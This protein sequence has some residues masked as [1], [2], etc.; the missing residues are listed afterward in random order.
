[1]RKCR[2]IAVFLM[3]MLMISGCGEKEA[4]NPMDNQGGNPVESPI[5]R[6][7]DKPAG[8]PAE[9]AAPDISSDFGDAEETYGD[10]IQEELYK[11]Y[12]E[13]A[14]SDLSGVTI[15]CLSGSDGC[16]IKEGS[17]ITFT[18]VSTDS[19]YTIAGEF[20][21][22]IVIDVGDEYKFEL[23]LL[24]LSVSSDATNPI[25]IKSGDKVT[26]T[27]KKDYS[28]Y[29]YDLRAAVDENSET[30]KAGAIYSE[31]DL[32]IGGKGELT[33]VSENN[34]GIHSKK[35]LEVKNVNLTVHCSDN[36]LKGNDSVTLEGASTTLISTM[37][38][39]IKTSNSDISQ[40]GN[41]RGTILVSGGTYNVYAACDGLD[42]AYDVVVEDTAD[43]ATVVN[44]FTDKYSNYS[45][46]VTVVAED[47][48]YI[49]SFT[50]EWKYSVKYYN[51]D[52][53]YVW[54]T[55]EKHSDVSGGRTSY[56]YYS[57]PKMQEYSKVQFFIYSGDMEQGQ[58]TEYLAMTD[59]LTVNTEYDTFALAS[60]GNSLSYSWTNYTTQIVES[61]GGGRGDH[62]G[63]GG[64]PGGF[65]GGPGGFGGMGG[66]GEGNTD[67][68]EYSTKGIK[69]ANEIVINSGTVNIKAYDDA[70]HANNDSTL[71]NGETPKGNVI[72]NDGV[73][74]VYSNDDGLHADG[75][76]TVNNGVVTVTNSYE[77]VEG[78]YVEILGGKVSVNA[79][80][81]GI[82]A[83]TTTGTA[84]TIAG[85]DVY[86]YCSGDGVD[87]NSRTSYE[88][89]VFS[90]GN[91]V[92][93][94]TS[95]G[96]SAIDSEQGYKY[97]GGQ[98]V[99]I[100]P[101]GGMSQE[102]VHC[103]NFSEIGSKRTTA[104]IAGRYVNVAV[105][106]DTVATIQMPSG[107]SG[108]VIYLG[109]NGASVSVEETT[110]AELDANGVCWY[111]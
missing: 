56:F 47:V 93:I 84:V 21:G 89:I 37:G 94:S 43:N 92:T 26:L 86:I 68:G 66:F 79:K 5:D 8:N 50:D 110:S 28:N 49:R 18:N 74:T 19:I 33:V 102:A 24:G 65:G 101:S 9:N 31:V 108:M 3:I 6:P 76:V 61:F 87:S 14:T 22:N 48:F 82:N 60:Q 44:I 34:N 7:A 103:K 35:D 99:A 39:G 53:D 46:E 71:E 63:F 69:A 104:M 77:G 95:G 109:S 64:G 23:E 1:M 29:V 67:K 80:D 12:S 13:A 59:Y 52:E 85:G 4:D 58:E 15:T 73:I 91:T 2:V 96:N 17:A 40:K 97:E 25:M 83:T 30:E 107:I 41:Q 98:V 62:G 72:I 105:D 45:E 70:I 54:V 81:D 51:S 27:A 90:G 78:S 75:T 57:Y 38:D 32:R 55:P 42:A 16:Y 20:K 111:K 100:M 36:A 10:D 11:G 88:G 106:D